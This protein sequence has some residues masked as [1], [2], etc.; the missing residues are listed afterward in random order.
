MGMLISVLVDHYQRVNNRK[1]YFPEEETFPIDSLENE[2]NQIQNIIMKKFHQSKI[3]ST[4]ENIPNEGEY[5]V[6]TTDM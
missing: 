2:H 6:S 1:K 5:D 4:L 3:T